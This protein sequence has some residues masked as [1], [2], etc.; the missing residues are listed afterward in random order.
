MRPSNFWIDVVAFVVYLVA[1]NPTMT[2]IGL[3]EWVGLAALVALFVHCL[4]HAD[5]VVR[6]CKGAFKARSWARIGVLL[7]DAALML[8]LVV[9]VVSGIMVSG[10]VLLSLGLFAQGYFF[11]DPLHAASAKVL[12]V[13][14]LVHLVVH[15]RQVASFL[16]HGAVNS[17][18][19]RDVG[20][21]QPKRF[22]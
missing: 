8:S 5:W 3:H 9:C 12:L 16:R 4:V 14:L 18:G 17:K 20:D 15:W 11:W 1:A 19:G 21:A 22:E 10:D 7:L 2:G 6:A 13:L